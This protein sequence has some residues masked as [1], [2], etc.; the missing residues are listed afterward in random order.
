[1]ADRVGERFQFLVAAHQLFVQLRHFLGLAQHD[2]DNGGAHFVRGIAVGITPRQ[3][4]LL[5]GLLP[6]LERVARRQDHAGCLGLARVAS[7]AHGA[8][9]LRPEPHQVAVMELRDRHRQQATG[10][11]GQARGRRPVGGEMIGAVHLLPGVLV[12]QPVSQGQHLAGGRAL[13][14]AHAV[15]LVHDGRASRAGQGQQAGLI[16]A[17]R[18]HELFVPG[19]PCQQLDQHRATGHAFLD[20]ARALLQRDLQRQDL[21][22]EL[23][24]RTHVVR[25]AARLHRVA[26]HQAPQPPFVH[27]RHRH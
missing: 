10:H 1:M 2:V 17:Q 24:G 19:H 9:D 8:H 21:A 12:G 22:H 16:V 20:R 25:Q 6:R 11:V 27:Q 26:G 13:P 14:H 4:A 7:P 15:P 18:S 5:H 23:T 3:A